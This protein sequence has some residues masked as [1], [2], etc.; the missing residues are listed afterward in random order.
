MDSI[1]TAQYKLAYA[2]TAK[3]RRIQIFDI[4]E[5]CIFFE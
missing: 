3:R 2:W 4:G 1:G 5:V